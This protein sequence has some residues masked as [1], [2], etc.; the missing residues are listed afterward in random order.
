MASL[1]TRSPIITPIPPCSFSYFSVLLQYSAIAG[2]PPPGSRPTRA[3]PTCACCSFALLLSL[4]FFTLMSSSIFT[5]YIIRRM[6]GRPCPAHKP[7]PRPLCP[8]CKVGKTQETGKTMDLSI[9][10]QE[11]F[12]FP[13]M[14]TA[15]EMLKL[16]S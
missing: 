3:H 10:F 2:L 12:C 5:V 4:A 13:K 7:Q 1:Y 15:E 16:E 6:E 9:S 14:S 8:S 11:E